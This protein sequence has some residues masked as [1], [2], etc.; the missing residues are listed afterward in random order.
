MQ[1]IKSTGGPA[2]SIEQLRHC[3]DEVFTSGANFP[4]REAMT[5]ATA[6]A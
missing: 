6:L 2:Q 1:L 5:I 4:M 3:Q